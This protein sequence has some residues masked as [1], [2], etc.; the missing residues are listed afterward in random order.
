M[1]KTIQIISTFLWCKNHGTAMAEYGL[2]MLLI[3]V[4]VIAGATALGNAIT[5][6]YT[7]V[8]GAL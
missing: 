1:I 8:A 2:L 3:A 4:V 6:M 7:T 5:A